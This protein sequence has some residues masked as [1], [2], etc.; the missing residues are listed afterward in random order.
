MTNYFIN[1]AVNRLDFNTNTTCNIPINS[2]SN[3][4]NVIL[5]AIEGNVNLFSVFDVIF[6]NNRNIARILHLADNSNDI[7]YS[8]SGDNFVVS[9]TL[10]WSYGIYIKLDN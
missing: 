9:C 8:I 5:V 2:G 4:R 3:Y 1:N 7:K 6:I 10:N